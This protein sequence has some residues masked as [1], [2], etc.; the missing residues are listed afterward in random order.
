LFDIFPSRRFIVR[1]NLIFFHGTNVII[2][3]KDKRLVAKL[4]VHHNMKPW[5][6]SSNTGER[7]SLEQKKPNKFE[8]PVHKE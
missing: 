3:I 1:Y 6:M 2:F 8:L 4:L 5:V 7:F